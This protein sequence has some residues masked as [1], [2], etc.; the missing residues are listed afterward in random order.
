MSGTLDASAPPVTSAKSVWVIRYDPGMSSISGAA[1]LMRLQA[2]TLRFKS[3]LCRGRASVR[4]H[5]SAQSTWLRRAWCSRSFEQRRDAAPAMGAFAIA[6]AL[7]V[8]SSSLKA[9]RQAMSPTGAGR[10]VHR[11]HL[12]ASASRSFASSS[13]PVRVAD[14]SGC[15]GW[16]TASER[17]TPP[18]CIS[19]FAARRPHWRFS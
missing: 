12:N 7:V 3:L 5:A 19:T 6:S 10:P 18:A 8:L 14:G 1:M 17:I 16:R 4:A 2:E 13:R 15:S 9:S 11:P